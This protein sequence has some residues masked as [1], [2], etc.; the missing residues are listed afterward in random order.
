MYDSNNYT[1]SEGG[2]SPVDPEQKPPRKNNA[3]NGVMKC[4]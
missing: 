2:F 1:Y 4:I 3:G